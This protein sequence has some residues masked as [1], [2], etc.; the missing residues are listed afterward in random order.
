MNKLLIILLVLVAV[1]YIRFNLKYQD[2]YEILQV[3]PSKL[4]PDILY[5]KNPIII[6]NGTSAE[7]DTPEQIINSSMKYMYSYKHQNEYIPQ[8][9]LIENKSR[10]LFISSKTPCEI[11]IVN[12]K[13]KNSEDYECVYIK[14]KVGNILVLPTFWKY[15]STT[16]LD[17][18]FVHDIFS[19]VYHTT[20][21]II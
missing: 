9:K 13:F 4:T 3:N 7:A 2:Y 20:T 21:S 10:Y 6:Y 8:D 18:I 12:P 5:E 17:C 11:E 15:K 19:T 16:P 14:L 1:L